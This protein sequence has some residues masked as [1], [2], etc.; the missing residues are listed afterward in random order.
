VRWTWQNA[1]MAKDFHSPKL[2]EAERRVL[3]RPD[4]GH[5]IFGDNVPVHYWFRALL[6]EAGIPEARIGVLN[7]EVAKTPLARQRIAE[8]FNGTPALLNERGEIEMEGEPPSIDVVIANAT[9]YEGIDLQVRTC[10]VI[11]LDLPWEPATLQQRNGRA[12]RQGN[13]QAVIKVIYILAD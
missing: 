4:C 2:D 6:I 7:A 8:Q 12:V 10:Q 5:I 1:K 9:A 13:T 3:A 11:H